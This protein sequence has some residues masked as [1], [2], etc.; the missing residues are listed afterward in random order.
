MNV[1]HAHDTGAA[2]E[3]RM[4]CATLPMYAEPEL[5]Q[6]IEGWW[7]GVARHLRDRGVAGVPGALTWSDDRYRPWRSPD[8]LFSQTCGHPLVHSVGPSV[9]LVATPHYAASGCEGP[10]Y[11]SFI[12]VR[13]DEAAR[14]VGELLGRRLA[15]N[16]LDSWSGYH[17]W[18]RILV[19][20]LAGT[21]EVDEAFGP[22]LVSGSHRE[23]IRSVGAGCAD[24]CAV[25]C[26]SYALLGARSPEV[27]AGTR[28]LGRS[29]P[30]LALPFITG[31]ATTGDELARIREGL[32]AALAD[33][34]LD[35]DRAA[36]LL[37]GASVTTEA[38]YRQ[39]FAA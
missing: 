34:C 35:D 19:G 32:F 20:S 37:T 31:A 25:D 28:V 2:G 30:Q 1:G 15:V 21:G 18:R 9:Q 33:P 3:G 5:R 22:V 17:V 14:S 27:L 6:A 11:R 24:L 10:T 23:S 4:R 38:D 12:V 36:L 8:L 29:P 26:V 39:A 13:E 16:G 7:T